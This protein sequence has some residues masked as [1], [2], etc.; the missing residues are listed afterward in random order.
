MMH[1]GNHFLGSFPQRPLLLIIICVLCF[2][3]QLSNAEDTLSRSLNEANNLII[4]GRQSQQKVDVTIAETTKLKQ[5]YKRL[6]KALEQVNI[7]LRHQ[8]QI[9]QAQL[10]KLQSIDEQFSKL[11]LTENSII[12]QLFEMLTWLE[13]HINSDL[14]FHLQQRLES[15]TQL[16]EKLSDPLLPLE[17][18][19]RSVLDIY[20]LE[21]EYGY[22][23][24]SYQ[25]E[26]NIKG[27]H[28]QAQI[29]RI[30]RIGM[31]FLS[32]D[33]QFGGLWNKHDQQWE[34]LEQSKLS[35]VRQAILIAKKQT[36][37]RLINLPV[38]PEAQH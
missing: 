1:L 16:K 11:S 37:P 7:N 13:Q 9:H 30:G 6:S 29:L 36:P 17:E 3:T 21:S 18:Q 8:T 10:K 14:P 2:A 28:L 24:D 38:Y 34:V 15:I 26:I 32:L 27:Q 33:E 20:Q 4:N 23:I 35:D 5:E 22:S 19:Y 31:Y 25:G 12:P